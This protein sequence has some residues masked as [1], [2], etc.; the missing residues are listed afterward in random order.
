MS[1][2]NAQPA[3][4]ASQIRALAATGL[5]SSHLYPFLRLVY[6][7]PKTRGRRVNGDG[8]S[9]TI[10][11]ESRDS[12]DEVVCRRQ[13]E[14]NGKYTA[15]WTSSTHLGQSNGSGEVFKVHSV[16]DWVE[17]Q[18]WNRFDNGFDVFL[19]KASVSLQ[20]LQ[21]QTAQDSMTTG[22]LWFPLKT[23]EANGLTSHLSLEIECVFTSDPKVLRIREEVHQRRKRKTKKKKSSGE[24]VDVVDQHEASGSEEDVDDDEANSI[25]DPAFAFTQPFLPVEWALIASTSIR[26]LFFHV[27]PSSFAV[28]YVQ[29]SQFCLSCGVVGCGAPC[30]FSRN[31]LVRRPRTGA[32][33][34]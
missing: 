18:L 3:L 20:Q 5:A 14:R 25:A 28:W 11:V 12:G 13:R 1:A 7:D 4:T 34:R 2:S 31:R 16:V 30:K 17:L 33:G 22:A 23:S 24:Q 21:Q 32:G 29:C 9:R 15:I 27:R 19:G 10:L 8:R 26:H 6:N